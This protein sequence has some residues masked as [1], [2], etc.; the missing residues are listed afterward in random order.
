MLKS[1]KMMATF[2]K[3][4]NSL[5]EQKDDISQRGKP[6]VFQNLTWLGFGIENQIHRLFAS[7]SFSVMFF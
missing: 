2:M 5:S 4:G 1:E 6:L 7:M 3:K